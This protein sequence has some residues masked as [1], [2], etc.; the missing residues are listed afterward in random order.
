MPSR[1][2]AIAKPE[3]APLQSPVHWAVLGLI[4]ERPDYG[5]KLAQRFERTYAGAIRLSS[6]SY[7]YQA[8]K[9][10]NERGF[11]D[12]RPGTGGGRQ[13]KPQYEASSAGVRAYQEHL[14][15][16]VGEDARRS[17]LFARKLSVLARDPEAGL[18]VVRNYRQECM[19]ELVGSSLPSS[20]G[21]IEVG[22]TGRLAA[23]L[24]AEAG[25]LAVEAKLAWCDYATARLQALIAVRP[26]DV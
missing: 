21:D 26:S 18:A 15:A 4:I 19:N 9:V 6:H 8:L 23:Q 2:R 13:P 11:I 5:Y 14:V 24:E 10:L 3:A 16:E 20:G 12:E 25:R 17:Q 22:P 7:I 1:T